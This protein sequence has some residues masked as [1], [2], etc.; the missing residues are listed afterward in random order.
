MCYPEIF[1]TISTNLCA[2]PKGVDDEP[3]CSTCS[4]T[5]RASING[6]SSDLFQMHHLIQKLRINIS[7]IYSSIL[8][9]GWQLLAIGV[10]S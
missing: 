8:G 9:S 2:I 10:A 5:L 1:F 4:G 7:A 3:P 6:P